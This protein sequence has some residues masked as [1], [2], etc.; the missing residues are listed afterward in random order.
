MKNNR[1]IIGITMGDPVG[2]GPEIIISAL[3]QSSVYRLCKPLVIGDIQRLNTAKKVIESSLAFKTISMPKD[4]KFEHGCVDVM[5][6]SELSPND[7]IWGRPTVDTGRAMVRYITTA[8]DLATQGVINATVTCPINK[9]AMQ[10]AGVNY[11]GHTELFADRTNTT[12]FVMMLAG[13]HLKV[14]P[15]TIHI[16]L[17]QIPHMLSKELIAKTIRITGRSLMERFGIETPRIAVAGLNPHAGESGL[18]GEEERQVIIPAIHLAKHGPYLVSGPFPPDTVFH[19]ASK[20]KFDVVISMYHDQGLIP[21]KM[22][23]FADGVNTTLGLPIIRTSVDHGTAY[24]IAGTGKANPASLIAAI[25]M[26]TEQV[27]N[28]RR[29][30]KTS[31]NQCLNSGPT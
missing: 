24:D 10:I 25:Q 23:H 22:I 16:P 3:Q 14:V 30:V 27:E 13:R 17:K 20:G 29:P 5:N 1:P 21:F 9:Q 6:L 19:Y 4:C 26:A 7:A 2:I 31:K 18:F 11:P 15:A 12:D 28:E 8:I